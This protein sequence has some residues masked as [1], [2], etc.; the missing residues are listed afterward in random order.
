MEGLCK[1]GGLQPP[2]NCLLPPANK[3]MLGGL[4]EEGERGELQIQR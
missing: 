4:R 3:S 2:L 1:R